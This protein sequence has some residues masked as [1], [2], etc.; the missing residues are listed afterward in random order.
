[1]NIYLKKIELK[2]LELIVYIY[3]Y[4]I[5]CIIED[6]NLESLQQMVLKNLGNRMPKIEVGATEI[7]KWVRCL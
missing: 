4:L 7:G 2:G 5:Y 3:N 1:M 6:L